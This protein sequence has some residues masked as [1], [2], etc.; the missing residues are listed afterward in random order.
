MSNIKVKKVISKMVA[1]GG[2]IE[3]A[4]RESGYSA[5]Y[6]RSG[7]ITKTKAWQEY[8]D[9]FFSDEEIL[10]VHKELIEATKPII[11]KDGLVVD[12]IDDYSVQI[13]ALDMAYKIKGK[14][15]PTQIAITNPYEN[16]TD[17]ELTREIERI[18]K[19]M[20]KS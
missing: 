15:K 13:R 3:K 11:N 7:K 2:N 4:V 5:A 17:E 6:A 8:V 16:L 14:Y 20:R 18:E 9:E 12:Y 19:E 10:K 1:N